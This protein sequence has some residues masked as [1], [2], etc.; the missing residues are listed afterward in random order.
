A[1]QPDAVPGRLAADDLGRRARQVA[2]EVEGAVLGHHRRA[3]GA[4]DVDRVVEAASPDSADAAMPPA[5]LLE[6]PAQAQAK[7]RTVLDS[8]LVEHRL[9]VGD[10]RRAHER[11]AVPGRA[12]VP[13][14]ALED[15]RDLGARHDAA[16][17]EA[18]AVHPT[19]ERNQD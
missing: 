17:G 9:D 8:A 7:L 3:V 12:A 5:Q 10:D 11:M 6:P 14:V 18:A 4:E 2:R 19:D 13:A 1:G 16:D 15:L